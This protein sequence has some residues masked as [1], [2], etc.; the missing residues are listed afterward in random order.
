MY[1]HDNGFGHTRLHLPHQT[2]NRLPK[3]ATEHVNEPDLTDEALSR[4]Q[5]PEKAQHVCNLAWGAEE[6]KPPNPPHL[7]PGVK[8]FFRLNSAH[9]NL[10]EV[11]IA[12]ALGSNSIPNRP[13]HALSD[14]RILDEI[15]N[16]GR[17][18]PYGGLQAAFQL[19]ARVTFGPALSNAIGFCAQ[20]IWLRFRVV[21]HPFLHGLG[22]WALNPK[23][24]SMFWD[25]A[26]WEQCLGFRAGSFCVAKI[27]G[28]QWSCGDLLGFFV[29]NP[30]PEA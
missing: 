4:L 1:L 6:S 7:N 21:E 2:I 30:K 10:P 8:V 3:R 18:H 29:A 26:G 12:K 23:P 11:S 9:G 28:F 15:L 5:T 22:C 14:S 25:S 16:A 19:R 20:G 24:H 13:E 17:P 27:T